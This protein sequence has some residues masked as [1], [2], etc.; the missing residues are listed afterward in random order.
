[1]FHELGLVG[2]AVFG[3]KFIIFVFSPACVFAVEV[4]GNCVR[5]RI[6]SFVVDVCFTYSAKVTS[7]LL[8]VCASLG[9]HPFVEG[10]HV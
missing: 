2:E 10:F 1:V 5:G 3:D 9:V 6:I 7:Y 4:H 8:I